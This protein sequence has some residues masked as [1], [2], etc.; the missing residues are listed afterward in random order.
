MPEAESGGFSGAPQTETSGGKIFWPSK[1]E[2]IPPLCFGHLDGLHEC[3]DRHTCG[4]SCAVMSDHYHCCYDNHSAATPSL[5]S[6][7]DIRLWVTSVC[8][9]QITYAGIY[10]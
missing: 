10:F 6:H 8:G 5:S 7:G 4:S 2:Q 9:V 1:S 3:S